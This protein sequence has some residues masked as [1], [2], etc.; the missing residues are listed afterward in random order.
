M[1]AVILAGGLGTRLGPLTRKVPKPMVPVAGVPYLEHQLRLLARQSFRD[2]LL[3]TGYLGEQ[4]ESYFGSGARLGMRLRY[5]RESQPQGTGGAL[6]DARRHLAETFLLL[7]G[8]S[9]LPI[10][11][12]AAARRLKDSAALGVVV[13]YRDPS[14]ETAVRPNVALDRGLVTRYDKTATAG[15]VLE[16]VE[17]GV[18]CFRREVL[19]LLPAAMPVSFEQC[20]FPRLIARRQ[21]AGLPT[22]QRFYDIGTPERLQAIEEYLRAP[23][24]PSGRDLSHEQP[25]YR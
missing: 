2:V 20:V 5:S 22:S 23:S 24:E 4:I 19:D 18:S 1:Q 9:L 11:Y 8:D 16:Y 17:A 14:G 3:L 10:Q 15:P 12:A 6:R 21:L 25:H 7:Y 13:V